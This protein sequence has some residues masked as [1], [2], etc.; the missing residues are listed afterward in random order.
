MKV[1][2][3]GRIDYI[4]IVVLTPNWLEKLFGVKDKIVKLR[5]TDCTYTFGGGRI[6]L[7]EDGT[8]T[9]NGDYIAEEIDKW[10]RAW[11]QKVSPN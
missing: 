11:K 9:D 1:K 10:R 5:D 7:F 2:S 3:I 6:Y 8:R 4:Y